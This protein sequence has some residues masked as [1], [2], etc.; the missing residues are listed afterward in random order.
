MP[1][2]F[3]LMYIR[4][5]CLKTLNKSLIWMTVANMMFASV[6]FPQ[7]EKPPFEDVQETFKCLSK[8]VFT[9]PVRGFQRL[10][11]YRSF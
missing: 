2:G 4:H 3:N 8:V 7:T 10:P 11:L 5:F 9:S 1:H 6:L